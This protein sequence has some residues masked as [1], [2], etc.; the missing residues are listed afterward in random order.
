MIAAH[1]TQDEMI[2]WFYDARTGGDERRQA[3]FEKFGV[4][5]I[6]RGMSV[7]EQE[8]SSN[9]CVIEASD[10]KGL[11]FRGVGWTGFVLAEPEFRASG[12]VIPGADVYTSLQTGVID[13]CELSNVFSQNKTYALH[14]ACKYAG[15]PGMHQF[16]QTGSM[17]FNMK[18]WNTLPADIQEI[19]TKLLMGRP[20]RTNANSL[21]NCAL[22]MDTL[23]DFGTVFVRESPACQRTWRDVSWRI[24]DGMAARSKDFDFEWTAM[25]DHMA[26]LRPY[27]EIQTPYM[28]KKM[29]AIGVFN[30]SAWKKDVLA[31]IGGD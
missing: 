15:F 19:L 12:I 5:S 28:G 17:L 22:M 11:N 24:A 4:K 29:T 10:Y 7:T 23:E 16:T 8:Y 21:I 13:A 1:F 26:F 9:R 31:G 14:E 6:L 18:K 2:A 3:L 20:A 27:L 25:K 30:W